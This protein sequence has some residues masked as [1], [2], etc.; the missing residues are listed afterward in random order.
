MKKTIAL[1]LVAIM[2]LFMF[3]ACNN[4]EDEVPTRVPGNNLVSPDV[5]LNDNPDLNINNSWSNNYYA[6]FTYYCPA[7]GYN[8]AT[9]ISERKTENCFIISNPMDGSFKY[10]VNNETGMEEYAVNPAK[11]IFNYVSH[12]GKNVANNINSMFK[13]VSMVTENFTKGPDVVYT[14]TETVA[15]RNCWM[16]LQR[17]YTESGEVDQV[18]YIWIDAVYGFCS[19]CIT[20]SGGDIVCSWELQDFSVGTVKDAD[21]TPDLSSYNFTQ[22]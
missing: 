7:Q 11:N 2:T 14:G 21:I 20:Y 17:T 5:N 13:N 12:S 6:M 10:Y 9:V 1:V 4:A 18:A 8:T 16:Y 3:T 22:N 15:D 19:K